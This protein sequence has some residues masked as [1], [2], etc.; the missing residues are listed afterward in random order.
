VETYSIGCE[1]EEMMNV[2]RVLSAGKIGSDVFKRYG[3]VRQS[4]LGSSALRV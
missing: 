1:H 3:S 4:A 2:E